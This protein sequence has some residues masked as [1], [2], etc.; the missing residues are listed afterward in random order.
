MF[1]KEILHRKKKKDEQTQ[2]ANLGFPGNITMK[3]IN[4]NNGTTSFCFSS[5][6]INS[7]M[8]FHAFLRTFYIYTVILDNAG[9]A[10]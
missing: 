4:E 2:T 5:I 9:S 3:S 6:T 1:V 10:F 7:L 8:H